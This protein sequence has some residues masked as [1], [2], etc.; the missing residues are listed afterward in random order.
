M[1]PSAVASGAKPRARRSAPSPRAHT[2]S[3]QCP[4]ASV[5][6]TG[7]H[8]VGQLRT[9]VGLPVGCDWS[10][11][12]WRPC[13]RG[14]LRVKFALLACRLPAR[15]WDERARGRSDGL[16]AWTRCQDAA[17]AHLLWRWRARRC[18][19]VRVSQCDARN[20]CCRT[21]RRRWGGVTQRGVGLERNRG[22][23]GSR[24]RRGARGLRRASPRAWRSSAGGGSGAYATSRAFGAPGGHPLLPRQRRHPKG[25]P[26]THRIRA[27]QL[28]SGR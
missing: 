25:W 18:V 7:C 17:E 19:S 13:P 21:D 26:N 9:A 27:A 2:H 15:C 28:P 22:G 11:A 12:A 14:R 16:L 10:F 6:K 1:P 4:V 8:L 24:E 20:V 23:G 5:N 3:N